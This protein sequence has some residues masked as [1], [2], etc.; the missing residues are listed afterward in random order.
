MLFSIKIRTVRFT[1]LRGTTILR[2]ILGVGVLGGTILCGTFNNPAY[3]D[4]FLQGQSQFSR[5]TQNPIPERGTSSSIKSPRG[6]DAQPPGYAPGFPSTMSPAGPSLGTNSVV[7]HPALT[8]QYNNSNRGTS[9]G[10]SSPTVPTS[11]LR[12]DCS[13]VSRFDIAPPRVNISQTSLSSGTF[14]NSILVEGSVEGVCLTE[15][16]GF[17]NGRL[18][19]SIPIVTSRQ[20]GRFNFQMSLSEADNPEIRV[21]NITGDSYILPIR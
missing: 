6:V 1:I 8:Q 7:P 2:G 14:G 17:Q 3:A 20:F 11:G 10:P 5:P 19:G 4:P 13:S 12:N 21:Y 18:V 16:G 15:A 9:F